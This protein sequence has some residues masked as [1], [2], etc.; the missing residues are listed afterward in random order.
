MLS[1]VQKAADQAVKDNRMDTHKAQQLKESF[2]Q[3]LTA[4]TYLTQ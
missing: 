2:A 1:Q 3:R 4:Y